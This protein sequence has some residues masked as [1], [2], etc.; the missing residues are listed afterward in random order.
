LAQIIYRYRLLRNPY[1]SL[2]HHRQREYY[3]ER[4]FDS[5][6]EVDIERPWIEFGFRQARQFETVVGKDLFKAATL[7]VA[8]SPYRHF[9]GIPDLHGEFVKRVENWLR[10]TATLSVEEKENLARKL[11]E[12]L[13]RK[14]PLKRLFEF[15][16]E[17]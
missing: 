10:K 12:E 11:V 14:E 15:L 1:P 16:I 5:L 3:A 17:A 9:P 4:Y 7:L 8:I 6:N 13:K 2:T